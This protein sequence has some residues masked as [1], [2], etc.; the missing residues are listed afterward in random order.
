VKQRLL[1]ERVP[2]RWQHGEHVWEYVPIQ[3]RKTGVW[4]GFTIRSV[5][6]PQGS[7]G[8]CP[9]EKRRVEVTADTL[10]GA[11][12]AAEERLALALREDEAWL[13][14]TMRCP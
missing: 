10:A 13:R 9:R 2:S 11:L 1:E 3:N 4:G 14:R 5:R 8:H 7:K 12:A 6:R